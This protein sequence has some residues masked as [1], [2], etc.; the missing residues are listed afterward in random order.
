MTREGLASE[1]V[2]I[3]GRK[4]SAALALELWRPG[5]RTTIVPFDEILPA[6]REGVSPPG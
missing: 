4:T 3:P 5:T 6:V 2:A 1:V